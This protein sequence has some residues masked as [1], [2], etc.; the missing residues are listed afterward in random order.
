MNH[1]GNNQVRRMARKII[2]IIFWLCVWHIAAKITNN[3]I[4]LVTPIQAAL[5]LFENMAEADFWKIVL[6]SFARIGSGF[7]AAF[8]LGIFLGV[9]AYVSEFVQEL[10]APVMAAVKSIPVASFVV[11]LLIWCG[12]SKLSFFIS[13]LVVLPNIYVSTVAGLCS[14]PRELLEMADVFHIGRLN[15]FMYIY[16]TALMP[17][18]VSALKVSLGMSWKSGAAAEI[19]GMPQYSLGE[20][21][22]MSKIYLDTA[23]LFSWT[24]VVILLSFIF[25]KTVLYLVKRFEKWKPYP[26]PAKKPR[27]HKEKGNIELSG[28]CKAYG[29]EKVID[30]FSYTIIRG[31]HYCLTA[32]SGAGKTTLLKLINRIEQPDSGTVCGVP[33]YIGM[34]F[35]EDRLCGGFDVVSNI[36]LTAAAPAD[37]KRIYEEARNILPEDS[38]NKPVDELSGGM[39]R[40]CAILRAMLSDSDIIIM[41]EPFYGLDDENRRKTARYILERLNGRT[42]IAATHRAEDVELL[43]GSRISVAAKEPE[44]KRADV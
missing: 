11:L 19:I 3:A 14:A 20:R 37:R 9:S 43:E 40:R 36:M 39:K 23:S 24:F 13:F 31:S 34:V 44:R 8:V 33:E 38:L 7:F 1:T 27:T 25:E 10:L 32:P 22:Y 21:L 41:D 4:L 35:Q 42:L 6:Y 30:G 26:I 16:R 28:V 17:Y 12:S 15:R 18:L 29:E 5:A 2:I